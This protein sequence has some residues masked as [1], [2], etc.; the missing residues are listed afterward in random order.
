M[1]LFIRLCKIAFIALPMLALAWGVGFGWF[2]SKAS[3]SKPYDLAQRADV[4][5]VL[6]GGEGRVDAGLNLFAAKRAPYLYITSVHNQLDEYRIR[7]RWQGQTP[8]PECCIFL[9]HQATTT[10]QN[11]L[12]AR[13]WII[14]SG[15]YISTVRL[16]TSNYHMPRA[17][18]DFK[19]LMPGI[20]FY[21]HP[22]I[23]PNATSKDRRYWT[24][25]VDEY[26]KYLVRT[27][28]TWLPPSAQ[29]A[30]A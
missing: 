18:V 13:D 29:E 2:A 7:A 24:L 6:T 22:I 14:N 9:D 4:V 19:R 28:Q 12:Q 3:S 8:L 10:A 21:P 30:L 20:T 26:N 25:L 16:V 1:K 27:L 23:S 11:A 5:I 15:Q 17:L